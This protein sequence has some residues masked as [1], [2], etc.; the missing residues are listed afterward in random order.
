[1]TTPDAFS[2]STTWSPS[3]FITQ[4]YDRYFAYA[5]T[6]P[7][8]KARTLF[9]LSSGINSFPMAETWKALLRLELDHDLL[10]REYT[11]NSGL[12]FLTKLA[13]WSEH[14][15]ST[16][17][18]LNFSPPS[19]KVFMTIGATQAVAIA[20]EYVSSQ[21]CRQSQQ[22]APTVLLL[23]FNYPLFEALARRHK[24]HI[25]ECINEQSQATRTLPDAETVAQ[26]LSEHR[27]ALLVLTQP[28]NP[29]GEMYAQ[30]EL[31]TIFSAARESHSLIIA[32]IVGLLPISA[33]PWV[34]IQKAMV[35][36]Q[37]QEQTLLVQSFSKTDS[38]PGFRIGY[39]LVPSALE[40]Y[41]ARY[42]Y[43]NIMNPQTF[44]VLPL[45]ITFLARNLFM[46]RRMQWISEEKEAFIIQLFSRFFQRHNPLAHPQLVETL[47]PEYLQHFSHQYMA[48]Q[49]ANYQIM[50]ENQSY[51]LAILASYI[52]RAT[53]RQGGFNFLV[54]FLPWTQKDEGT[55]CDEL[56]HTLHLV[57]FPEACF[58]V[59]RQQHKNNFW[60]RVTL[61]HPGDAFKQAVDRLKTHFDSHM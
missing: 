47:T 48:E 25:I 14:F 44:P 3:N 41:V 43:A 24:M 15:C 27:P 38:I 5:S 8:E 32:D 39:M 30:S 61:A 7:P 11:S 49:L 16:E 6:L 35:Q 59:Y 13:T 18:N 2:V 53:Q 54:E 17:G 56:L 28:N 19:S 9:Q 22:H 58:R 45:L 42:Q 21:Q 50:Q 40:N 29:S 23:G 34:N 31:A 10:Y 46:G 51:F 20:F 1:M 33:D 55:I 4:I 12:P 57:I 52:A 60:V 26:L 37:I 36:T